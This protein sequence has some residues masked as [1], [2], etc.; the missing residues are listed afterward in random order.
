MPNYQYY[1]KNNHPVVRWEA[2]HLMKDIYVERC[3]VCHAK[4]KV[5]IS[6]PNIDIFTP[7][8]VFDLDVEPITFESRRQMKEECAKRGVWFDG[9]RKPKQRKIYNIR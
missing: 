7:F 5:Q 8:T 1:C 6:S 2:F 3:K 9:K 4:G